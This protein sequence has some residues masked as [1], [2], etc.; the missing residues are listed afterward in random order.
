MNIKT[1]FDELLDSEPLQ[2]GPI[3]LWL[4]VTLDAFLT[5]KRIR[6]ADM[7]RSWIFDPENFFFDAVADAI[8][9]SPEGLRQ[10]IQE[11]LER[12]RK[13]DPSLR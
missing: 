12:A 7:A 11:A 8:G 10:R 1:P 4:T 3:A 9:Y 5:L 13:E 6:G 2:P